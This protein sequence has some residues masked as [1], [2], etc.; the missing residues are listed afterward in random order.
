MAHTLMK[1]HTVIF[2]APR[3]PGTDSQ[4]SY[5][6]NKPRT[7]VDNRFCAMTLSRNPKLWQSLPAEKQR[8]LKNSPGFIAIKEEL[9]KVSLKSKD[10]PGAKD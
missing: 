10:D 7:I 8:E 9:E 4:N 6:G 2:Y 5:L 1:I 3:N